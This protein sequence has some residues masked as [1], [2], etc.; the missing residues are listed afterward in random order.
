MSNHNSYLHLF[1]GPMGSSKTTKL[2]EYLGECYIRGLKCLYINYEKDIRQDV[3]QNINEVATTH[4]PNPVNLHK[5]IDRLRVCKLDQVD[6]RDYKAI[7]I[8]EAHFYPDL[9]DMVK[10]WLD[11]GII[12]FCGGLNADS[13]MNDIGEICKLYCIADD[14]TYLK[15]ICKYCDIIVKNASFT[16]RLCTDQSQFHV[17]GMSD[18]VPVCR[19]HYFS[20]KSNTG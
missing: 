16:L 18:Y 2:F 11:S 19:F 17:G 13:E 14:I 7:A 3:A 6:I 8:D 9:F 1:V 4:S 20:I 15:S 10:K 12:I 5:D